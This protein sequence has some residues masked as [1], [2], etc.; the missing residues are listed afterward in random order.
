MSAERKRILRCRLWN[1]NELSNMVFVG[2]F[3]HHH[4]TRRLTHYLVLPVRSSFSQKLFFL[5]FRHY[6]TALS[7]MAALKVKILCPYLREMKIYVHTHTQT[8]T[9]MSIAALFV[10][11]SCWKQ[12]MSFSEWIPKHTQCLHHGILLSNE[13]EGTTVTCKACMNLQRIILSEKSHM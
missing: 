8:C 13:K 4:N 1:T 9:L 6:E 3:L 7:P 10:E 5:V 11:V 12:L 2:V